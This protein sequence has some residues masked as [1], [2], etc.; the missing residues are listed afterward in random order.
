A[1]EA[2]VTTIL[3]PAPMRPDF[4]PALLEHVAILIPNETEFATLARQLPAVRA[5]AGADFDDAKLAALEDAKLHELCRLFG[6]ET[7]IVTL[8]S[9]G[10]FISQPESSAFIPAMKGIKAVDTTGAGD[11]FVGAFATA[12]AEFGPGE[13]E[14]AARFANAGA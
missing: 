7:M 13:I 14:K 10:C 6:V 8:G 3:N 1:Q 2:G 5:I 12:L 11:A 4:D 9:R